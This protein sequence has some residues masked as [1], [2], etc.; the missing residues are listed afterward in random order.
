VTG[1]TFGG[2]CQGRA[3]SA[4]PDTGKPIAGLQIPG[5]DAL[6]AGA[7]NLADGLGLGYLGVDFVLDASLGPV[8][9]EANARPGLAIQVA[10][11]HGLIPRLDFLD[12][13]PPETLQPDRRTD[14]VARLAAMG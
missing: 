14:L 7:V 9:L 8:I 5:W 2:V 3:G 11:R 4:H 12:S 6:L 1:Q 10:N 13:Q